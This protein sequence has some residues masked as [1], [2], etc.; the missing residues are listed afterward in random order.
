MPLLAAELAATGLQPVPPPAVGAASAA[1]VGTAA[2]GSRRTVLVG[3]E[4][5]LVA[6]TAVGPAG[7]PAPGVDA[8]VAA[9]VSSLSAQPAP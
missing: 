7:D 8:I 1:L 6:V 2:N 3:Y 5:Y 9:V 4:S